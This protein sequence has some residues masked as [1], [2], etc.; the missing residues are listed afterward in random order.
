RRRQAKHSPFG[1]HRPTAFPQQ[2]WKV[3]ARSAGPT[4][5]KASRPR[6]ASC[7]T[8]GFLPRSFSCDEDFDA[9][10]AR[11]CHAAIWRAACE[12]VADAWKNVYAEPSL[13]L[14]KC[15]DCFS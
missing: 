6:I 7:Q 13:A 10:D 9:E 12:R 2:Q 8:M 1:G 4:W 15:G 3:A 5:P 11:V 14:R